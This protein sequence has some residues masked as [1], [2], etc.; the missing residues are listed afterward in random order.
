MPPATF[1]NGK[2]TSC[3]ACGSAAQDVS[4]SWPFFS[5]V[6]NLVRMMLLEH[7]QTGEETKEICKLSNE[8]IP[9]VDACDLYAAPLGAP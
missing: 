9:P 3:L 6:D 8:F 2:R 4:L 5:T 1:A 7:D